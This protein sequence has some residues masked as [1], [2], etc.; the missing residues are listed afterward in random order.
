MVLWY[1][2][3]FLEK[4]HHSNYEN[5]IQVSKFKWRHILCLV[6]TFLGKFK[7]N[8]LYGFL[9]TLYLILQDRRLREEISIKMAERYDCTD[10]KES[11]Y[12]QK[13]ILKEEN[14][15][16]IKCYEALY[17]NNCELC[18]VLIGCTSKVKTFIHSFFIQ[19]FQLLVLFSL[20]TVF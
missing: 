16:C 20:H 9:T 4:S 5:P 17:S 2:S 1:C 6:S 18:K 10:C 3:A 12:G 8:H 19:G 7:L 15:Y 11:L 13:Y 14:P